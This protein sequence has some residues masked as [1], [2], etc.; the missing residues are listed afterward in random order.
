MSSC[1]G[2]F[3]DLEQHLEWVRFLILLDSEDYRVVRIPDKNWLVDGWDDI[4]NSTSVSGRRSSIAWPDL[5]LCWPPRPQ[6][7]RQ[8][9][10]RPRLHCRAA[11][12]HHPRDPSENTEY[13]I[14]YL[15]FDVKITSR[16]KW[17][18]SQALLAVTWKSL[19]E[20]I[21]PVSSPWSGISVPGSAPMIL[22]KS[23]GSS[24]CW[25]TVTGRSG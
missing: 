19:G 18:I 15:I 23:V 13:V 14:L 2:L 17:E 3:P 25:T 12:H 1:K 20:S 24:P 11:S 9:R 6:S 22:Q 21:G 8:S 16:L 5:G 10:D 7:P 4:S